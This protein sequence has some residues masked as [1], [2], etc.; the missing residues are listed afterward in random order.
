MSI[1]PDIHS[2]KKMFIFFQ[3]C[4]KANLFWKS[5]TTWLKR[6]KIIPNSL[7]K[8]LL[9]GPGCLC[10]IGLCFLLKDALLLKMQRIKTI[11]QGPVVQKADSAI[12]RINHYPA[13][14]GV[15]N[16]LRY[17]LGNNLSGGQRYPPF[18]QPGPVVLQKQLQE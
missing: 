13:D 10:L 1:I 16:Q 17:P 4:F 12:H 11:V 5:E 14:K 18:E 9:L 7:Q 3:Y 2:I 6:V 15:Q 8:T